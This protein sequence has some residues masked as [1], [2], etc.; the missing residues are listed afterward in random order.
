MS[1]ILLRAT[2]LIVHHQGAVALDRVSF[3]CAAGEVIGIIGANGAGKS[4]L[5]NALAGLVETAS[6]RIE[7]NGTDITDLGPARRS[8]LGLAYAPEGRRL[9]AG[10]SVA[11]NLLVACADPRA[12][13]ER[14][15]RVFELFPALVDKRGSRAWQLSG[16]QQQMLAIGRALMQ[17]P[18][19]LLLDEPSLGLAPR[20]IDELL[21]ALKKIRAGGTSILIA[22][23]NV[24]AALAIADRALVLRAGKL[25]LD[26]KAADLLGDPAVKNS[27]MGA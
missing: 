6:G 8:R 18:K 21:I 17:A 13:A 27:F 23:Q 12:R 15:R 5:M 19:L 10:M 20:L 9:F 1:E 26:G 14:M 4:T 22:E 16:G 2:D 24:R 3:E 7:W 11:D 25:V